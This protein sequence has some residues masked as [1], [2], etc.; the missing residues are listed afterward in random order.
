MAYQT[1][2]CELNNGILVLRHDRE[3]T[4]NARNSQMY[5]EIMAALK[6]ASLDDDVVGVLLTGKGRFFCAGMDFNNQAKLA[7]EVQPT[8]S[9][10]VHDVKINL[11]RRDEDDVAT[12]LP[13]KFIESFISF[14][15]LL[16]GAVNGPAIGEGFSSLLH[17]DVVYAADSAYFWAPFAR[18]GVAPE[19]CSTKLM[20]RKLGAGLANAAIYLS[21]RITAEEARS[22]GFVEAVYASGDA[23]EATVLSVVQDGL[24]L[25]GPP[26][27]RPQTLRGYKSLVFDEADRLAMIEQCRKEFELIRARARS[28]E[29]KRVQAHYQNLLPPG[30]KD[31]G[32]GKKKSDN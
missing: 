32:K 9:S 16:I 11:P 30:N 26:E 17:C 19:F 14:D 8:D 7:Y 18:A 10:T 3:D 27:L 25:A 20:A 15:K 29:T 22:A 21:R 31:L 2:E 23:F 5:V 13:V 24:D 4:L 28:G 12:W 1:I 6:T